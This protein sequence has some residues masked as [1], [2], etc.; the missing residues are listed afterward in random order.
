MTITAQLKTRANISTDPNDIVGIFAGGEVRGVG[1]P[2][3]S[4]RGSVRLAFIQV[5]S[6]NS[7][8]EA[9][10]FRIYDASSDEIIDAITILSF[11]NDLAVGSTVSPF[12]ITDNYGPTD[13][14]LSNER[15]NENAPPSTVVGQ[16]SAQDQDSGETFSFSLATGEGDTDNSSFSINVNQLRAQQSFN[17]E[18]QSSYSIRLRVTDSKNEYTEEVFNIR[19]NDL[20]D[21]PS[22]VRLSAYNIAENS[23]IG[24]QVADLNVEDEDINPQPHTYRFVFGSGSIDNTSFLIQEQQLLLNIR[25]DFEAKDS[26]MIRIQAA[27]TDGLVREEELTISVLDINEKP[28]GISPSM[29]S[30]SERTMTQSTLANLLAEDPD[31]GD[32]HRF[33]LLSASSVF[34][35]SGQQ[36]ML[37]QTLNFEARSLYF[38]DLEITDT[39]GLTGT[40]QITIQIGNGDDAPSEIIFTPENVNEQTA[41]NSRVGE[42]TTIDEDQGAIFEY[43]LVNG[44]SDTHNNYFSIQGNELRLA[45][46]FNYES[47]SEY[48]FH[49]QS[50]QTGAPSAFIS[51]AFTLKV[52]DVNE[53][54]TG[55]SLS[56]RTVR[57]NEPAGTSAGDI[58]FSDPDQGDEQILKLVSGNGSTHNDQF[59]IENRLLKTRTILD[60]EAG[61]IRNVR[62]R[63]QDAGSL[64]EEQSF[65]I[66]VENTDE[67]LTQ[68][69]LSNHEVQE[70]SAVGTVVGALSAAIPNSVL[71][72]SSSITYTLLS[73]LDQNKFQIQGSQ[74]LIQQALN[75]EDQIF[76]SLNVQASDGLNTVDQ[77]F[78]IILTNQNEAPTD[79]VL[80]TSSFEENRAS[81]STVSILSTVDPDVSET[82]NYT[83]ATGTGDDDN[84]QFSVSSNRLYNVSAF[85]FE[86]KDSYQIRIS[87]QDQGN[88]SIEKAFVIQILDLNEAPSKISFSAEQLPENQPRGSLVGTLS[89]EDPDANESFTYSLIPGA[90][91]DHNDKFFTSNGQV[92][93]SEV[94]DYEK[95]PHLNLR[96]LVRDKGNL[97]ISRAL[98]VSIENRNDPHTNLQLSSHSIKEELP[99][100]TLIGTLTVDDE[101][102]TSITYTITE[103]SLVQA[104]RIEQDRLL[105]NRLFDYE[106]QT[107]LRLS[108]EASDQDMNAISKTF[109]ITI[110]D[111][112]DPPQLIQLSSTTFPENM[113]PGTLLGSLSLLDDDGNNDESS[114]TYALV[115]GENDE[116]NNDFEIT[117]QNQ[118]IST[119]ALNFE[120]KA[121]RNIRVQATSPNGIDL[122]S[123]IRIAIEN[124]NDPPAG[125]TLSEQSIAEN[126]PSGTL[127]AL[128]SCE[129]QDGSNDCTYSLAGE[130]S[131]VAFFEIR[132]NRLNTLASFNYESKTQYTFSINAVDRMGS[133]TSSELS[134]NIKDAND[135][136]VL[137]ASPKPFSVPESSPEGTLVGTVYSTDE[138]PKQT[139]SYQF[140]LSSDPSITNTN[141]YIDGSSGQIY[142]QNPKGLDYEAFSA[143][144]IEV[145]AT[146]NGD[147]PKS[148]KQYYDID[149]LDVAE[150]ELP[151]SLIISPNGDGMND[152]WSIENVHIYSELELVIF[153][154]FGQVIYQ[155]SNY[156]NKWDA[157]YEGKPLPRGVYHY[158]F[159]DVAGNVQYRGSI[160]VLK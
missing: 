100:G 137:Q 20:N 156:Q 9:L 13:I 71:G 81:T 31:Q 126:E 38:L 119:R 64:F 67:S 150:N 125:V 46:A 88:L 56:N 27:D 55:L 28:T 65:T 127:V 18:A 80:R 50:H 58:S 29:L 24:T 94:F 159:K 33:R 78:V 19:V 130:L 145:I 37:L 135:P 101:D 34:G 35:V 86:N 134:I 23:P 10:I 8:G 105:S 12:L 26:Y 49:V 51:R 160:S 120:K 139:I 57:E 142:V 70:N 85:D 45:N 121:F 66:T 22:I 157:T 25:P 104:F 48:S 63:V 76:Y 60:Y 141:Y 153:S 79:L 74:L 6:N 93:A 90:G 30:V 92:F 73:S 43:N 47:F 61:A 109:E 89:A 154:S 75:Y 138:D 122:T 32:T 59:I 112:D 158:I 62:I 144:K 44:A 123:V 1:S 147:P 99:T 118:L 36:L 2:L 95:N 41:V 111:V 87:V 72:R 17:F 77:N 83:L 151:A 148:H 110:T 124:A 117:H 40:F 14:I 4:G 128:I 129:D 52:H 3:V 39:G 113:P 146:D 54:P 155:T 152:L 7:S 108:I 5:Y 16:L 143:Q 133:G 114:I 149:L 107:L 53:S 68:L 91:S 106:K 82:F 131:S 136:P 102:N 97:S 103:S 21:P 115:T 98:V 69:A 84:A 116:D 42:F 15:V 11:Q 96:A 132:G 140:F